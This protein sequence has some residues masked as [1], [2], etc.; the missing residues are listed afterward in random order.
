MYI[1]SLTVQNTIK[2]PI[3]IN[4]Q[5]IKALENKIKKF[6]FFIKVNAK[7]RNITPHK[8]NKNGEKLNILLLFCEFDLNNSSIDTI[9]SPKIGIWYPLYINKRYKYPIDFALGMATS[10]VIPKS[11]RF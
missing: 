3:A 9:I 11:K 7:L 1:I 6:I 5:I 10:C 2:Y 4:I 8:Q